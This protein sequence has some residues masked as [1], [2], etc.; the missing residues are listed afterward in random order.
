MAL[1]N[2]TGASD[3]HC[4]CYYISVRIFRGAKSVGTQDETVMHSVDCVLKAQCPQLWA[5]ASESTAVYSGPSSLKW[6]KHA[7]S[8]K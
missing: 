5:R 7:Q 8:V 1:K 2:S 4:C 6:T 3:H